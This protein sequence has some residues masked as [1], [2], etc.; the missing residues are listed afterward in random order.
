MK[1]VLP[2]QRQSVFKKFAPLLP[3]LVVTLVLGLAGCDL[4]YKDMKGYLEYWTATAGVGEY[5]VVAEPDSQGDPSG[6]TTISTGTKLTVTAAIDNPD[7]HALNNSGV[8]PASD[9]L[10]S[11]RISGPAGAAALSRASVTVGLTSLTFELAPLSSVPTTPESLQVEHKDFTV[12]LAP[13]RTETNMSP[14]NPLPLTFRYNTPP[15]MPLAVVYDSSTEKL[16]WPTGNEQWEMV[17]GS[18]SGDLDGCIFWAWP[19]GMTVID[20]GTDEK[21]K[22][23]PNCIAKFLMHDT[24]LGLD[25]SLSVENCQADKIIS[26]PP[27]SRPFSDYLSPD[28][29]GYV[30]YCNNASGSPVTVYA[31]DIDGVR[32]A[33]ITSSQP[34]HAITLNANGG[35]FG[36]RGDRVTVYRAADSTLTGGDLDVPTKSGYYL[37]GWTDGTGDVSFPCRA[38]SITG[39]LTAQWLPEPPSGGSAPVTP[40]PAGN[41]NTFEVNP[42]DDLQD[43]LDDIIA[44][45]DGSSTYTLLLKGDFTGTVLDISPSSPLKLKISSG[46]G[47][48]VTIDAT[49]MND[50]VLKV[51]GQA[52][53]TLE[54]VILT[55]GNTSNFGG[56]AYVEG[57][58]TLE[59]GTSIKGN[60]AN[61]GGG[62]YVKDGGEL[63][64]N[65]GEIGNNIAGNGGGVYVN[66]NATFTATGGTIGGSGSPNQATSNGGGIFIATD[67]AGEL[68]GV[69]I[70]H[71]T[72]ATTGGGVLNNGTLTIASGQI[73]NNEADYNGGGISNNTSNSTIIMSGGEIS[74]NTAGNNGGGIYAAG[75][76]LT[77]QNATINRNEVY[78]TG[79]GN[80]QGV[81]LHLS[82]ATTT[83]TNTQISG[84]TVNGSAQFDVD[85]GG[86]YL[87]KGT[88]NIESGAK[89]SGHDIA[90]IMAGTSFGGG[91]YVADG[92]V[93]MNGGNISGNNALGSGVDND[94][95]QGV[96]IQ[97]GTF[98]MGGDA[99]V[100]LGNAVYLAD[101]KT[102]TITSELTGSK[103][104]ANIVRSTYTVGTQILE[105]GPGV[106]LTAAAGQF[107]VDMDIATGDSPYFVDSNGQLQPR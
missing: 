28:L 55:G 44:K 50:S 79:G 45:N 26:S 64:M 32:G 51:G 13:V 75:G 53:V 56:G 77:I 74:G 66:S 86:I 81:G 106:N 2:N 1:H 12:L 73:S 41:P 10:K 3:A 105:A 29:D 107:M 30:I 24:G 46:T 47:S 93:N 58:L 4:W 19:D 71:N 104:V 67:G 6:R 96:Y 94:A 7:G 69:T 72:A 70:S 68:D 43:V 63:V 5:Q 95:G 39:T 31:V 103:L 20:A 100:D 59:A 99:T 18:P 65:D 49:G 33:G 52:D 102:I 60:G 84:N 15:R 17:T 25:E 48:P 9:I 21:R 83:I 80:I 23:H 101:G 37:S 98:N 97:N 35:T 34:L 78:R 36:T 22:K 40:P 57:K 11:V 92:T 27:S 62:V 54:N 14:S 85:G 42:G 88:L 61:E 82:N 8:G 89:I 87:N 16:R 91:L 76:R 90:H 38:D